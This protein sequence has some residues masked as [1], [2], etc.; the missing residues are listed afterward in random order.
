[1]DN[2][3]MLRSY[4]PASFIPLFLPGLLVF[5]FATVARWITFITILGPLSRIASKKDKD[6]KKFREAAWRAVLYATACGWAGSVLLFG[7]DYDIGFMN[8]SELFWKGWPGH[9]VTPGMA[10]IYQLYLGLYVHLLVF[11][12]LDTKSSDFL[13]LV[14]H[15]L[16]TMS[17][18]L[19][20]WRVSFTRVGSFTMVLH[21]ISDV[22][23]EIAKCFNYT[24]VAHPRL[25][26]GADASFIVF[27]V[28][29]FY[30]RLYIYPTRVVHSTMYQACVHVSCITP[31]TIG[32]CA[33][34]VTWMFFNVLLIGL[35]GLQI[36]WGWKVLGVIATVIRGKPLEDPRDE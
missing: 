23:L 35:Q 13:A 14:A 26:I 28:T 11:L 12:F 17:I 30:L 4:V 27:A 7:D 6:Q 33:F 2:V 36:F 8:D 16:I 18:V 25:S 19:G 15:H 24:Q 5:V 22:F 29:F 31:P 21:D 9:E 1:M 34:N 32:N 10:S 20:S 3:T